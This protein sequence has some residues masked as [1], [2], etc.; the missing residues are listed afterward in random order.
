MENKLILID[1]M[2]LIFR[3][4]H[5]F[6]RN[7]RLTSS[8]INASAVYGFANTLFEV[9]QREQPTHVGVAFE[10]QGPTFRH[11]KY[12]PYKAQRDATPEDI[13]AAIPL[14][15]ELLEGLRIPVLQVE[16][17]EADDVIGTLA[18]KAAE[19]DATVYML[20]PDKDFAQ[21]VRPGVYLYRISSKDENMYP[22]DEAEVEKQMG[23]RPDQI[24]DYLGLRGDPVDNIPGIPKVGEKTALELLKQFDHLE[25]IIEQAHR[26]PK[27]A[28]RESVEQFAE[29]GLLSKHLATIAINVPID[30]NLEAL[31]RE[32]PDRDRL[33]AL[34]QKLEFR[35]LA[36]RVLGEN[37]NGSNGATLFSADQAMP[38]TALPES[39][40]TNVQSFDEKGVDYRLIESLSEWEA[41]AQTL[42]K[43]SLF[44][45]DTETTSLDPLRAE[46]VGAS[47]AIQAE[48]AWFLPLG[49]DLPDRTERLRL[50]QLVLANSHALKIVQNFKFDLA[51][52]RTHGLEV[53]DPVYDTLL[54]HYIAHSE[55]RHNLDVLALHYLN[56]RMIAYSELV[57]GEGKKDKEKDIREIP[58]RQLADYACEDAD[59]TF[60]LYQP[61]DRDLNERGNHR[62]F[63]EIE[64]PTAR[65][66]EQ[67]ERNGIRVDADF[68]RA[69]S[70]DLEKQ[71]EQLAHEVYQAAGQE[72]NLN[73]PKQLGEILFDKLKLEAPKKTK[74]GQYSTTEAELSK[75]AA[76]G[77]RLPEL[78][79][80]Y[81]HMAKLKS[82]YVDALPQLIHPLTGRV[83]THYNQAVA[84]T[85]RLSSN[86]PNLQ[87]IPVKT[88][89]GREI[90]KAFV[91]ADPTT[92]VLLSA[93]YS[94]IELRV[95]AALSEDENMCRAFRSGLDIH[96]ATAARVFGVSENEV[97]D[98][99]RRKA[100]MVN[101]GLIY[102]ITAFGLAERLGIGRSEAADLIETY[103]REYRGV[104]RFMDRCIDLARER[105]Y[106]ETLM[107][108][109]HYLRNLGSR[110]AA[111][112]GFAERNAINTPI[113]GT[114]ADLMKL[115]M[116][117]IHNRLNREGFA[118]RMLLQVHDELLFD[119]PLGEVDALKE[120][121]IYEMSHAVDLII[122]IEVNTG[123]GANWLDAH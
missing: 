8:G 62:L 86:N 22:W 114:A 83:H 2:A 12:P 106:A 6:G 76:K 74:T 120:L 105:G 48:K 72:F 81:R 102:G 96:R 3:A 52:L 59:I 55:A 89:L 90:R 68:L 78:I 87:N 111:E 24:T 32:E 63:E 11:L 13:V 46:L 84:V 4:H 19:A 58:L 9:L 117:R 77:H 21:I 18:V 93:D 70:L 44:S 66:L 98:N 53:A 47:F 37:S 92:H 20:T 80:Q 29:Q 118:S 26:I 110:N 79:L 36:K 116:I 64:M 123:I 65:V 115:A 85:G 49:T 35:T 69:Y 14:V 99:M 75:L 95:M 25:Q 51:V 104:K 42:L 100:K 40:E 88:D 60:R 97:D 23:V 94:Q 15:Q 28:I 67:M 122:P 103:F 119:V 43:A 101:F 10:S 73:S 112:R 54:A 17:Y 45:F 7:P 5:V 31:K 34:F 71:M 57:K 108:R 41:V 56:Y 38:S 109:R 33:M 91:A 50:L 113:Q 39:L 82:T 1:A 61:I 27:K 107:G 16:G 30:L 121:V